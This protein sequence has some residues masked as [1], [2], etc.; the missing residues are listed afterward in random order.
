[1]SR[2]VLPVWLWPDASVTPLPAAFSEKAEAQGG[3]DQC[4]GSHQQEGALQ[5]GARPGDFAVQ[6]PVD[7]KRAGKVAFAPISLGACRIT[8]MAFNASALHELSLGVAQKR[9][10]VDF[11][12]LMDAQ[13]FVLSERPVGKRLEH[14]LF[15]RI[16]RTAIG[17]PGIVAI[18]PDLHARF[19]AAD[20]LPEIDRESGRDRK[21]VRPRGILMGD[22]RLVGVDAVD[23]VIV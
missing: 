2:H 23:N 13:V 9:P 19:R 17:A 14:A 7:E 15:K 12:K 8:V 18:Q 22:G 4:G 10:A 3:E 16:L 21:R 1:M 5:T 11:G 20:A 6:G